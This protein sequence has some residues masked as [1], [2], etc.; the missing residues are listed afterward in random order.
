M[1]GS[2]GASDVSGKSARAQEQEPEAVKGAQQDNTGS[3]WIVW[4]IVALV[5]G[6]GIFAFLSTGG[7]DAGHKFG[8]SFSEMTGGLFGKKPPRDD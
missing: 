1:I 8:R 5:A 4:L 7:K 2:A 6:L 3:G